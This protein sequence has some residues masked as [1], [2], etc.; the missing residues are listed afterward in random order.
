MNRLNFWKSLNRIPAAGAAAHDWELLLGADWKSAPIRRTPLIAEMA[1]DPARPHRKL[2][3]LEEAD[4]RFAAISHEPPFAEVPLTRKQAEAWVLD[5]EKIAAELAATLR[6]HPGQPGTDGSTRQIGTIHPPN[7]PV[8]PVYLHIP[9]G[10]FTDA[11][12]L[13]GDLAA[14]P[15]GTM[16]LPCRALITEKVSLLAA[17]RGFVLDSVVERLEASTPGSVQVRGMV[18]KPGSMKPAVTPILDAAPDWTWAKLKITVDPVGRIELRY[19][20]HHATHKFR[21]PNGK[22]ACRNTEI[23]LKIATY[24]HWRNP[25]VRDRKN[26]ADSKAFRRLSEILRALVPIRGEPFDY[27]EKEYRPAFQLVLSPE[28]EALVRKY[29]EEKEWE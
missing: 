18:K 3:I 12:R 26:D 25:P 17:A 22:P 5:W 15:S 11:I 23:L 1:I 28:H 21:K 20:R 14:M 27:S 10:G 6:F 13:L 9:A 8:S 2:E 29:L 24:G 7:H 4:D 16:F 19:G